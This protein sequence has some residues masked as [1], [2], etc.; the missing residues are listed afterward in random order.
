MVGSSMVATDSPRS[1]G[2]DVRRHPRGHP[3]PARRGRRRRPDLAVSRSRVVAGGTSRRRDPLDENA[4]SGRS[5][6]GRCSFSALVK[7]LFARPASGGVLA[8]YTEEGQRG[9]CG[10]RP[11]PFAIVRKAVL[12]LVAGRWVLAPFNNIVATPDNEDGAVEGVAHSASEFLGG[13]ELVIVQNLEEPIDLGRRLPIRTARVRDHRVL[14]IGVIV[15]GRGCPPR[16][17]VEAE[18]PR[19]TARRPTVRRRSLAG[20]GPRRGRRPANRS[21]RGCSSTKRRITSTLL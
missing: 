18:S 9:G 5:P 6:D 4:R 7:P 13:V 17:V 16:F 2:V 12:V 21:R 19:A 11:S 14:R 10:L 1:A 20:M 15:R 3:L 8:P